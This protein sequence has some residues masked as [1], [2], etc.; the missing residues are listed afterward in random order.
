MLGT[1]LSADRDL[2]KLYGYVI[3]GAAS[4]GRGSSRKRSSSPR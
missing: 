1:M 2:A 4:D 3:S